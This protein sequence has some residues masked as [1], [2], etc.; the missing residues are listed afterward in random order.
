MMNPMILSPSSTVEGEQFC[1]EA[2]D[3][4]EAN[5]SQ[6]STLDVDDSMGLLHSPLLPFKRL[7]HTFNYLLPSEDEKS[8]SRLL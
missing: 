5:N 3:E 2:T 8:S 4:T 6:A 7:Q 1:D